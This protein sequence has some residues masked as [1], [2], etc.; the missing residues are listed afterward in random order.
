MAPQSGDLCPHCQDQ[1]CP[2]LQD[3]LSINQN[4]KSKIKTTT[5]KNTSELSTKGS[6]IIDWARG[7]CPLAEFLIKRV[8]DD[9]IV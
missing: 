3:I 6:Q 1:L 5:M 8:I 7:G 4:S 9:V 2:L